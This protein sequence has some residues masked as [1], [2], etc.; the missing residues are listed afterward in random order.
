MRSSILWLSFWFCSSSI[1]FTFSLYSL[2]LSPLKLHDFLRSSM[3][4]LALASKSSSFAV[5]TLRF[6]RF[7]SMFF[8]DISMTS[9]LFQ[10]VENSIKLFSNSSYLVESLHDFVFVIT[11]TLVVR[12]HFEVFELFGFR[13]H[14]LFAFRT[15]RRS[16]STFSYETGS[17]FG[18]VLLTKIVEKRTVSSVLLTPP[19]LDP[20]PLLVLHVP[21]RLSGALSFPCFPHCTQR[22]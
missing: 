20:I 15:C 3:S 5:R 12:S 8:M 6:A 2:R 1:F 16:I 11:V 9:S 21:Q 14:R 17:K 7:V 22:G 18:H 10:P 13:R 4:Y 19:S